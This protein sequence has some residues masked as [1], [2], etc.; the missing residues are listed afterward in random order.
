M[1]L[2]LELIQLVSRRP[3]FYS[4]A[5]AALSIT[6]S[7]EG[8]AVTN[9]SLLQKLIYGNGPQNAKPPYLCWTGPFNYDPTLVSIGSSN[10]KTGDFWFTAYQQ[11]LDDACSWI[12]SIIDDVDALFPKGHYEVLTTTRITSMLLKTN[13]L[14]PVRSDQSQRTGQE[15]PVSA[16]TC[17]FRIGWQLL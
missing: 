12:H 6:P 4:P 1:S 3:A 13:S 8:T 17:C 2:E 14:M 16:F 7:P 15:F 11:Y 10:C 5:A 9:Q